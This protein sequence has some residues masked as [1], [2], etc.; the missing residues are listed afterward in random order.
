MAGTPLVCA[1][2]TIASPKREGK[3]RKRPDVNGMPLN[4]KCE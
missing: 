4:I 1:G 3:G 2:F